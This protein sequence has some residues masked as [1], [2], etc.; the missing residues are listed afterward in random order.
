MID[1][2]ATFERDITR[3]CLTAIQARAHRRRQ[4]AKADAGRPAGV[5]SAR[6]AIE[7]DQIA[8]EIEAETRR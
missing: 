2:L 1:A 4:M 3:A 7:L 8:N 6:L 5:V